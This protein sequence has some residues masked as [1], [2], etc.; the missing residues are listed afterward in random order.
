MFRHAIDRLLPDPR[1]RQRLLFNIRERYGDLADHLADVIQITRNEVHLR[2]GAAFLPGPAAERANAIGNLLHGSTRLFRGGLG[3]P[4]CRV[5]GQ[6]RKPQDGDRRTG[7]PRHEAAG[8]DNGRAADGGVAFHGDSAVDLVQT[9]LRG[10]G[11]FSRSTVRRQR[12]AIHEIESRSSP[13]AHG[14]WR[15]PTVRAMLM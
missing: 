7:P 9:P 4:L 13:P 12:A 14:I 11:H 3:G 15:A 8:Q 2:L 10:A 6:A 5:A 1:D